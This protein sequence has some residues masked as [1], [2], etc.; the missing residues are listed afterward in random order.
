M[1]SEK[2]RKPEQTGPGWAAGL[3]GPSAPRHSGRRLHALPPP[4]E[5]GQAGGGR[6]ACAHSACWADSPAW[7]QQCR[8]PVQPGCCCPDPAEHGQ[9]QRGR[10]PVQECYQ[11]QA[12]GAGARAP[13][14]VR[15]HHQPGQS[16]AGVWRQQ[17][18]ARGR[19]AL[20]RVP[21]QHQGLPGQQ[22]PSDRHH[23]WAPGQ[24]PAASG[25]AE[26]SRASAEGGAPERTG[27]ARGTAA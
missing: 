12:E 24:L 7:Q 9:A 23:S 4:A 11:G 14:S 19:G 20:Q 22:A 8:G 18:A 21:D 15:C 16:A 26:C 6:G 25:P 3:C 2:Q 17:Q 10:A 1:L 27:C 5:A 13:R